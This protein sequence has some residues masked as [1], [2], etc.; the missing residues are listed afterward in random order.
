MMRN[1]IPRFIAENYKH[2]IYQGEF[3]AACMFADISGFT[4]LTEILSEKGKE[5]TEILSRLINDVFTPAIGSVH[6]R[7]GFITSF[8]GDA[9]LAIFMGGVLDAM[10]S[11]IEI[12][13]LFEAHHHTPTKYGEFDIYAKF[14]LSV[15]GID[16]GI[17]GRKRKTFYF[18]GPAVDG[19]TQAEK[20]CRLQD[21]V[22]DRAFYYK[23]HERPGFIQ[24]SP[25]FYR[26]QGL[27]NPDPC[28]GRVPIAEE[29]DESILRLFVPGEIIDERPLDELRDIA[30]IFISFK[31]VERDFDSLNG[32][33]ADIM[34]ISEKWG[35][36]FNKIAFSDKGG[37][38]LINFGCLVSHERN[39]DRALNCITEI[40][41]IYQENIKA[42]VTFGRIFSGFIG[43]TA[44]S[45]FD[46]LGDAVNISARIAGK[47]PWGS[48]W[49]SR[50]ASEQSRKT[51]DSDFVMELHLKGKTGNTRVFELRDKKT[52]IPAFYR[53]KMYGR[54]LEIN[55][56]GESIKPLFAGK[57]GGVFYI[58]GE[59]GIGK[60]R[61]LYE[62]IK[63]SAFITNTCYMQCDSLL[64]KPW[65]PIV[66]FF[67]NYFS[68]KQDISEDEKEKVF[69]EIF[70]TLTDKL[71]NIRDKRA[72]LIKKE[73]IRTKAFI[74]VLLSLKAGSELYGQL[75]AKQRYE[76]TIYAVKEFFKALSLILPTV[77]QLED[78][79]VID[80][81]TRGLLKH[82]MRNIENY[83]IIILCTSRYND[84]GSRPEL[85]LEPGVREEKIILKGITD[86]SASG[87]MREMLG[88]PP[89]AMLFNF[90]KSKCWNNPFFT[91]QFCLYLKENKFVYSRDGVL[92]IGRE[93]EDIPSGINQI[94]IARIDRLSPEVKELLKIASVMGREFDRNILYKSMEALSDLIKVYKNIDKARFDMHSL[95]RIL[96]SDRDEYLF[97]GKKKNIWDNLD[98]ERYYFKDNLIRESAYDMQ[99]RERLRLLHQTIAHTLE[100]LVCK[101]EEFGREYYMDLAYHF[102]K[103]EINEKAG[104]YIGRSADYLKETYRNREAL[105]MYKKLLA[106]LEDD[107]D[108]ID[109]NHKIGEIYQHLGLLKDAGEI[110][111]NNIES[112]KKIGSMK[113]IANSCFKL[114]TVKTNLGHYSDALEFINQA[115]KLYREIEDMDGIWNVIGIKGIIYGNTG[116]LGNAME[117]AE[118]QKNLAEE[119]G[120]KNYQAIAMQNVGRIYSYRGEY[121]K[122]LECYTFA[123]R[124]FEENGNKPHRAVALDNMGGIFIRQ[125]LHDKALESLEK[126][127]EISEETGIK[128]HIASALGNIG[129]IHY[130]RGEYEKAFS[131]FE[132][133]LDISRDM[134]DKRSMGMNI[135][136]TGLVHE[137]EG[138]YKKA[139]ECYS[140]WQIISMELGDKRLEAIS[141]GNAGNIYLK[142][143][144]YDKARQFY[145][146]C[147]T[148]FDSNRLK[149]PLLIDCY[150]G[151]ADIEFA[152]GNIEQAL[153]YNEK[154]ADASR[155]MKDDKALFYID[156]QRYKIES[157]MGK[158][159]SAGRLMAQLKKDPDEELEAA[160]FYELYFIDGN[161]K[162]RQKA[163]KLYYRLYKKIARY[164]Y[165]KRMQELEKG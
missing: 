111:S 9:F 160:L 86:E 99:L 156:L 36:Y 54:D 115:M 6:C 152:G 59:A 5:G 42:G 92:S 79:H 53:G 127:R 34:E 69:E 25:G 83:P 146:V 114:G 133:A 58:Y 155:A 82:L 24:I 105:A 154:A 74:R 112:A 151:L 57:S 136:R 94:L 35:G 150:K 124:V 153:Y 64:K 80:G 130:I 107:S 125:G 148:I 102:E 32:F 14:G 3:E 100:V 145:E 65:N 52:G 90:I 132:Q 39:L 95:E 96:L 29:T 12:R 163:I 131:C 117:C 18:K 17:V 50:E 16:W 55:R 108:K 62:F 10:A 15:G 165:R 13:E 81:E 47:A 137:E 159:L 162:Y 142:L 7:N 87:M 27:S 84:D 103:A 19:C 20:H 121:D 73:L 71:D 141:R 122:A 91:E 46:V 37:M 61:L 158:K 88:D 40:R 109:A 149:D 30:S 104:E 49:L 11:A 66:Y 28:S 161:E 134:G 41:D 140:S 78:I 157:K 93:T 119:I 113:Q 89:D 98:A 68:L 85:D 56:L 26:V 43:S 72:V 97:E 63:T 110:F 135:G 44:R 1:L 70:R 51:F 67:Q 143:N 144:N 138:R 139:L 128:T 23:I 31:N 48:I 126:C 123:D 116:Q 21:I 33:A 4:E 8:E 106:Y 147:I 118:Q 129:S 45:S 120:N 60:T 77:I 22:A 164:E 76:N 38:A 101:A 75:D 2:G